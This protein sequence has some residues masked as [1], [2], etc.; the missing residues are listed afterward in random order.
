[1]YRRTL[2]AAPLV[3]PPP[4]EPRTVQPYMLAASLAA[5]A[6]MVVALVAGARPATA[7]M[8]AGAAVILAGAARPRDAL[9]RVDWSLLLFFGGLFIV[10]RAVDEAGLAR[11]LVAG[12]VGP[13]GGAPPAGGDLLARLGLA[14]TVLSQAVSNVP[15]V[16]LFV[17]SL[18]AAPAA[19]AQVLWLALAA[20]ATLAGNLTILG[21]VANVI[22]FEGARR[23]GVEVGFVEYLRA[24]APITLVTLVVAWGWLALA[25]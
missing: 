1:M 23:D 17:P 22:V 20:F 14:V 18:E 16:M 25:G 10:M 24:G 15:A 21:S 9:R 5:G 6:G 4:R 8:T 12:I 11:D 2:T 19:Q 3:V 13:L 7:A